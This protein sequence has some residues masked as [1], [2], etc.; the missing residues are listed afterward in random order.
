MSIKSFILEKICYIS[1]G[2]YW[3]GIYVH[4]ISRKYCYRFYLWGC[5]KH[6][7]QR[8]VLQKL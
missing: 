1:W 6:L 7:K 4:C 5:D 8:F 2:K 3:K